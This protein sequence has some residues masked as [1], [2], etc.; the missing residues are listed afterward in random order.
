[1]R[2]IDCFGV[3]DMLYTVDVDVLKN[4]KLLYTLYGEKK[5]ESIKSVDDLKPVEA[6][7]SSWSELENKILGLAE[8]MRDYSTSVIARRYLHEDDVKRMMA[9][10]IEM[11]ENANEQVDLFELLRG[12]TPKED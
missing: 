9:P 1:M 12:E 7:F 3:N 10:W 8:Y 4:G 11:A 2:H 6:E 5:P